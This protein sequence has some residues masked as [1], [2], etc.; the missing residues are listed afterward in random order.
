[1]N[2]NATFSISD[3]IDLLSIIAITIGGIFTLCK[4]NIS[5][6]I[7]RAEYIRNLIEVKNKELILKTFNLFDYNIEWYSRD[8]HR[9]NIENE[10]DYT[11]TY[12]DYVCYLNSTN[13][14]DTKTFNLFKYQVDSIVRNQQ[15]IDYMYNL[16]HYAKNNHMGLSYPYLL[17]YAA[18]KGYV[19]EDFYR[20]DSH[21]HNPRLHRYIF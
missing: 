5:M 6:R 17:G 11:L 19:N 21:K 20:I 12:F 13:I 18:Q 8:F 16:Y 2:F 1:M 10:V 3:I 14:F 9:S 4:W 7:K 15:V